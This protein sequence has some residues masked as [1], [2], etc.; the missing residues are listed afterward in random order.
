MSVCK[1]KFRTID[2][3]ISVA[4]KMAYFSPVNEHVLFIIRSYSTAEVNIYLYILWGLRWKL[5]SCIY[6]V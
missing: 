1:V 3:I 6:G 5:W 2:D 4:F